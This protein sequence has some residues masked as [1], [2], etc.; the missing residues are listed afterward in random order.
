MQ[1]DFAG[2]FGIY[3][4]YP[5]L[6]A[7]YAAKDHVIEW[8]WKQSKHWSALTQESFDAIAQRRILTKCN[9]PEQYLADDEAT[10]LALFDKKNP[11]IDMTSRRIRREIPISQIKALR[12]PE[13][14]LLMPW[15]NKP[16]CRAARSS[17]SFRKNAQWTTPSCWAIS[18][19][20]ER[21]ATQHRNGG[22][23]RQSSTVCAASKRPSSTRR[24]IKL[25]ADRNDRPFSAHKSRGHQEASRCRVYSVHEFGGVDE[26]YERYDRARRLERGG[27]ALLWLR[28]VS[29]RIEQREG[30]GVLLR[31]STVRHRDRA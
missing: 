26:H 13:G 7:H 5:F 4:L 12:T 14:D 18:P 10:W 21:S 22:G 29:H 9:H 31:G 24:K 28:V 25:H 8:F 2:N 1:T 17:T 30:H 23:Q 3:K 27:F 20:S 11:T 16:A 15:D 6:K 19:R